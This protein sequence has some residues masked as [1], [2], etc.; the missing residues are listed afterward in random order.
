MIKR[1]SSPKSD[2]IL[3]IN[4]ELQILTEANKSLKRKFLSFTFYDF[5]FIFYRSQSNCGETPSILWIPSFSSRQAYGSEFNELN[6]KNCALNVKII[7]KYECG[8]CCFSYE[9]KFLLFA[10]F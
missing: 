8:N 5:I 3:D 7:S 6:K 4:V 9:S 2:A 10:G 1:T